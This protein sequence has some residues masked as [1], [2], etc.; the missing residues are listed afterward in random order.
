V[1][2]ELKLLC[3][4]SRL[5]LRAYVEAAAAVVRYELRLLCS[6]SRLDLVA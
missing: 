1:R 3:S 6:V 4:V 5:V 2:Y